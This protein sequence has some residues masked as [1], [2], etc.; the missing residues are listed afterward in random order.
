MDHLH[1]RLSR[2]TVVAASG[3]LLGL[4]ATHLTTRSGAAAPIIQSGAGIAGGGSIRLNGM[5]AHFSVFGSRFEVEAAEE[6]LIFGQLR[7]IDQADEVTF[8]SVEVTN[9]GPIEDA[10]NAREMSGFVSMNGEG[11]HPFVLIV[12]DEGDPGAN[13]DSIDF[14]VGPDGSTDTS[15]TVYSLSGTL[16][17]GDIQLLAFEFEE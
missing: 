14:T 5:E 4:G 7:L 10:E 6:P 16:E 2:R 12:S 9:Y 15:D 17:S 13:T 11:R 3:A 8:E 1:A